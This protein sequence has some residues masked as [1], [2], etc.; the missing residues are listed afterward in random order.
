MELLEELSAT[1]IFSHAVGHGAILSIGTRSG[2]DVL[3]LGGLGD[4][5]VT[6]EHNIAR[7]G[8]TCIW[9]TSP[10]HIRVDGQLRG[11]GE[12]SQVEAKVQGAAQIAQDALHRGEVRLLGIMQTKANLL[13]GIGG[14][15]V[16]ERQVLEGFSEAHE[17][18]QINNRR[19]GSG[20]DL[21]LHVHGRRDRHA[22]NHGSVLKDVESE[23]ALSEEES[24]C[25]MMYGDPQKMM[26]RAEVLHSEFP[27]EG[28]Y[29]VLQERCAR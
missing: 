20:R 8:P 27:L 13:D 16:G 17:L 6:E 21:G 10:V 12:A 3:L 29:G 19:S 1:T 14:V 24:I 25:L 28:R 15:R 26:K 18:S 9:A 5:V 11:G 2:D 7:G 23:L 4:D 22:I